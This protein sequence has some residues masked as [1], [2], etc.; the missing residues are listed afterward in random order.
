MERMLFCALF[1]LVSLTWGTTWLAMKVAVDTIPPLFATGL[2]FLCAS[3]A[4]ILIALWRRKPLI[5]P[6]GQRIFQLAVSV[7]YFA[8]PFTLMIYSEKYVSAGLAS[9][10]F[11]NMPVGVLLVSGILLNEKISGRQLAGLI[12]SLT[13]L[14]TII[15]LE[16]ASDS[17][18]HWQGI[19]ALIIALM[20]HALIYV[21]SIRNNCG[22][23]VIT[24][25]ALPA[26]IA[27]VGLLITGAVL[28]KPVIA[29]F[30]P[31]SAFSVVYLGTFA[32]VG[33]ILS[34]FMLQKISTPFRALLVFMIFPFV[35]VSLESYVY[36]KSLSVTTLFMAV[37]LI[38]GIF[39]TLAGRRAPLKT[40]ERR[41]PKASVTADASS[42]E[43]PN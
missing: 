37:P 40:P 21:L 26:F 7:F 14:I 36:G 16:T 42:G 10:I 9:I 31:A 12:V 19:V 23:S 20:M 38:V 15:T 28:E 43:G 35:S 18:S 1:A 6:A 34:Y 29:D 24:F 39:I 13:S 22:V 4:L 33:G 8:I 25:N 2:R 41:L 3:P 11:A 30:A 17:T 32:G 5:F 27:G